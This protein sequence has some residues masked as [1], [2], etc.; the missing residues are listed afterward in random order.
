MDQKLQSKSSRRDF[1]KTAGAA[2]AVPYIITSSALG[3]AAQQQFLN[4]EEANR[5]VDDARREPWQL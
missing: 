1:I 4:D 3:D 2:L 5:L